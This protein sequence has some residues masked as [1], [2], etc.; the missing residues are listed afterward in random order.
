MDSR[1][2]SLLLTDKSFSNDRDLEALVICLS[3]GLLFLLYLSFL[4]MI[5]VHKNY[6]FQ[7]AA[8]SEDQFSFFPSETFNDDIDKFYFE[9]DDFDL[10]FFDDKEP[11][12]VYNT[13]ESDFGGSL[14]R[15]QD[16]EDDEE[17]KPFPGRYI[18]FYLYAIFIGGC[19]YRILKAWNCFYYKKLLKV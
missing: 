15:R 9:R 3:I 19:I 10:N 4:T 6:D 16:F 14:N 18:L 12:T 2:V 1:L 17:E 11:E 7:N 8:G 5:L 13:L